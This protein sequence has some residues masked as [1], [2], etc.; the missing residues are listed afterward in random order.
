M[1]SDFDRLILGYRL[2]E[3]PLS[4]VARKRVFG[5]VE[6]SLLKSG[7]SRKKLGCPSNVSK[8]ASFYETD[9]NTSADDDVRE[10]D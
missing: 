8:H 7:S 5:E 1:P 9:S 4:T 6:S 2:I 10:F 3:G